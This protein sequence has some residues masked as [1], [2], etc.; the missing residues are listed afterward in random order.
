MLNLALWCLAAYEFEIQST[1]FNERHGLWRWSRDYCSRIGKPL[2]RIGIRRSFLEPPNGDVTLDIDPAVL[3]IPGGVL[4]D[5]RQMP[6]ADK[7][8]GVCFNEHTLEHLKTVEDVQLAVKECARVAD[9]A[10]L[11]AP[12]P[13]SI[14][15]MLHPNHFQRL[16][17]ERNRIKVSPNQWKLGQT[18]ICSD[19]LPEV[20][21][22]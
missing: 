4:G 14:I 13:Y 20:I 17:F 16:W 5:E 1:E 10:V 11:L 15:S 8:F 21:P 22:R 3:A 7:Q 12:S 2:L 9:K 19:N 6:F 18:I